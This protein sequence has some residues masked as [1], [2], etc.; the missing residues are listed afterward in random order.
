VKFACIKAEKANF[1]VRM[2]CRLLE[3]SSSGFY[4]WWKR[5]PSTR[6]LEDQRLALEVAEVHLRSRRRYGSPRVHRE[7]QARGIRIGRKRVARLMYLQ[8]LAARPKRRI[9][10]TTDSTHTKA[11]AP[12]LLGRN[13]VATA[14]DRVWVTDI[15]Y[16]WTKEGWLYLAA[17]IDLFSRRVVG[18]A[19][20]ERIDAALCCQAMRN[21]LL[22]RRP[23]PGLILHSDRGGQFVSKDFVKLAEEHGVVQSR[24]R[25]GDCWDNAVAESFNGTIKAELIEEEEFATRAQCKRAL[26]EY[27][28]GFYN[29]SRLHSYLG[30]VS[31]SVFE[32]LA[33]AQRLAA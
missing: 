24:S 21:A 19:V 12:N 3:V 25:K 6:A 28:E 7:L 15:T 9:R 2:M 18:W 1:P 22:S 32:R 23:A 8:R 20:S 29:S 14:P 16:S 4:A 27:I 11:P 13:F 33:A 26:F 30:Y 5:G 31:P 10:R 17:V